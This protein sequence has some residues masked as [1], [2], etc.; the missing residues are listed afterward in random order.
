MR[1]DHGGRDVV[2]AEQFLNCPNVRPA[3]EGVS[4]KA[5][6]EGVAAGSLGES[7]AN[8][9][10]PNRL[11]NGGLI[12]VVPL[13]SPGARVFGHIAGWKNVLPFPLSGRAGVLSLNCP[14]QINPTASL[15]S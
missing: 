6:S 4:G 15:G 10:R 11:L 3:L 14:G 2:M 8:N 7:C 12:N 5:V 1:V 13:D 9:R